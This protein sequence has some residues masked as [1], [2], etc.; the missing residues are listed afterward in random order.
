MRDPFYG[1][2][3]N[4]NTLYIY[5]RFL[6]DLFVAKFKVKISEDVSQLFKVFFKYK[7]CSYQN[8]VYE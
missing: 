6:S 7:K 5:Y 1:T 8:R 2:R 4:S 3:R